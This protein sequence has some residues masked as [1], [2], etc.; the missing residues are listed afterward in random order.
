MLLNKKVLAVSILTSLISSNLNAA[1]FSI[2]ENSASGMGSAFAGAS[3]IAEDASTTFFNPAGLSKLKGKQI[4]F[5][6]HYISISSE[7]TN[8]GSS[9]SSAPPF[10]TGAS[11]SGSGDD[12]AVPAFVPNFY[13]AN[14]LNDKWNFGFGVNVPF[15][16]SS[17]YDDTWV[18]RYHATKSEI[19]VLNFNPSASYKVNDKLAVGFGVNVQYIEATLENQLDSSLIC[20]GAVA[21]AAALGGDPDPITTANLT[22]AGAGL[23]T[24]GDVTTDSSVSLSGDDLSLGWNIGLLYDISEATRIGLAYRSNVKHGLTGTANFTRSAGLN[25]VLSAGSGTTAFTSTGISAGVDLPETLSLSLY[26]EVDSKWSILADATWTKW[27]RFDK[28]VIDF[29]DPIQTDSTIPENWEDSMRYS[30]GVN[31]KADSKWTY[32]AGVALDE[33]PIPGPE[34]VTPRIPDTDR[35]WLSFGFGH[36]VSDSFSYDVG[37][38]HLFFDDIDVNNID[39]SFEHTLTGNYDVSVDLFSAQ[40]NW[41]F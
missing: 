17:E 26:H 37:Y 29:S 8:N 19:T 23:G 20:K 32:R 4:I 22:C 16:N 10:G 5:A 7:F 41:A 28:L 25:A 34:D 11:I 6:A 12:G 35:I 33:T 36:K 15:G 38:S 40:F 2:A 27:S 9:L 3:A 21:Q 31:Y 39:A 1:G 14:K 13:Y 24:L 30:L 18:G